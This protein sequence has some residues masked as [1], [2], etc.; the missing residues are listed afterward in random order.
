M[1]MQTLVERRAVLE[2]KAKSIRAEQAEKVLLDNCRRTYPQLNELARRYFGAGRQLTPEGLNRRRAE[3]VEG[4]PRI[5]PGDRWLVP[6][7]HVDAVG[8]CADCL[9]GPPVVISGSFRK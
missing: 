1:E 2:E 3:Q 4:A 6:P 7:G 5:P 9:A 8:R